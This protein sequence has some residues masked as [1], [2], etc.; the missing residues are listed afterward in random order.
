[1][2]NRR[3]RRNAQRTLEAAGMPLTKVVESGIERGKAL[4]FIETAKHDDL[5]MLAKA[6]GVRFI[7]D[8]RISPKINQR[9]SKLPALRVEDPDDSPEGGFDFDGEPNYF[10][11]D[12]LKD[13]V[14]TADRHARNAHKRVIPNKR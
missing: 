4:K 5:M 3:Q 14:S 10:D 9:S 8:A 11:E 12:E 13:E 2:M 1:M 7:K 6:I